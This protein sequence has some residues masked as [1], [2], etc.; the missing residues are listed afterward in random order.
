MGNALWRTKL[1]Q[2]G[3]RDKAQLA[4]RFSVAENLEYAR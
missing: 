4:C 2:W 1:T 3:K